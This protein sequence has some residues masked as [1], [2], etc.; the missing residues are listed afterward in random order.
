M[1][2]ILFLVACLVTLVA[3]GGD[4]ALPNPTGKGNIRM[5]NAAPGSPPVRF[6][7]EER[8]ISQVS[9][10]NSS[11]PT[12]Y[13]DF[14]YTFNFDIIVPGA[15]AVSRVASRTLQVEK[16]REL[17]F[18]LS[19]D[20][21][22]PDIA[23][24]DGDIRTF[25]AEGTVLEARF[26][27]GSNTL[28]DIDIYF[29]PAGTLPGTNPPAASLSFGE[30][31][32]PTDFEAG[33]FVLTVTAANDVNTVYFTTQ[34]T[35][36]PAGVAHIITVYDGDANDTGTVAVRSMTG[37]GTAIAFGD[38]TSPPAVRFINTSFEVGAVDIYDDDQLTNLV[39]GNVPFAGATPYL[40]TTTTDRTFYFT[41]AGSTAQVLIEQLFTARPAA[42]LSNIYV[43]GDASSAVA[44]GLVPDR[45]AYTTSARL[46]IFHGAA[47]N[48][49]FNA[50]L[51]DRG[52]EFNDDVGVI[53]FDVRY[54]GPSSVVELEE[55]SYDLYLTDTL[56]GNVVVS[57]FPLELV[58][59]GVVE[60]IAVDNVD[61]AIIDLVDISLP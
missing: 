33:D 16:D 15:S 23:I 13:D 42:T 5:I 54:G 55:G 8:L 60:L 30:I 7:I 34:D 12:D 18:F 19:G 14:S 45:A 40:D 20:I 9:Y 10:K 21:N 46:G 31:S 52:G 56:T 3:C 17:I 58:L 49:R 48:R 41:P 50:F 47:N 38:S 44:T 39:A 28:G 11:S 51:V 27:H 37:D 24:W 36:L 6:L 25:D 59:G 57:G 35:S 4:S 1:K 22:N 26:S 29:D 53:L 43:V 61:P 32:D 2:R